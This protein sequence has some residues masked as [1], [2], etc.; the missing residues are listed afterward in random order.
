MLPEQASITKN[1]IFS[2]IENSKARVFAT[3]F[4][5][6]GLGY[7]IQNSTEYRWKPFK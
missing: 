1:E 4:P 5:F 3:H 2:K 7:I 6:P